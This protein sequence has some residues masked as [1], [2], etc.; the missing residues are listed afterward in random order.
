MKI[1]VVS[2]MFPSDKYQSYGV[3]V[4]NFCEQLQDLGIDYSLSVM[5]KGSNVLSKFCRYA[6]FYVKTCIKC[7]VGKYDLVYVHYASN[8]SVPVLLALKFRKFNVYTNVHGSDVAPQNKKQEKMQKYTRKILD[9]SEKIIVPSY[10]FKDYVADK[11]SIEKEKIY[12]SFSGGVDLNVFFPDN[13]KVLTSKITVGFVSRIS[14]GKGWDVFLKAC[15]KLKEY[16]FKIVI[17]GSGSL[18]NEMEQLIRE[19]ELEELIDRYPM[20]SQHELRDV[21]SGLDVF[22]FSTCLRESLGLVAI[23]AMACGVPV[24]ASDYAAPSYYVQDGV[25]GY[26]F[27]KGDDDDLAKKIEHFLKLSIEERKRLCA[28]AIET[29]DK[30]K[31]ESVTLQMKAILFGGK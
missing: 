12:V 17:V 6:F 21:Y 23:E 11:Y 20:L 9:I 7:V 13:E 31:K 24:I 2:N 22:I 4:K 10:Y 15:A 25:N 16:N 28:G 8:S 5:K 26:K 30:Y 3:F 14:Y 29:A 19:L 18:D 1:L 27:K